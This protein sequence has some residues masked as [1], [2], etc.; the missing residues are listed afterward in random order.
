MFDATQEQNRGRRPGG[1]ARSYAPHRI[2]RT[3]ELFTNVGIN[4]SLNYY[5]RPIFKRCL[6]QQYIG[7]YSA[8]AAEAGQFLDFGE[9]RNSGLGIFR[10]TSPGSERGAILPYACVAGTATTA[11]NGSEGVA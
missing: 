6:L 2:L 5:A 11:I 8:L 10:D 4:L 9:F 1:R 3:S 7:L